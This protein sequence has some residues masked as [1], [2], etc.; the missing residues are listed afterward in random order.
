MDQ[1]DLMN[2]SFLPMNLHTDYPVIVRAEGRHLY[3]ADGRVFL[4]G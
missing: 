1:V 3:A 4:D 2:S